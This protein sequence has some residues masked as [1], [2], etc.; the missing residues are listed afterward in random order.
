MSRES[1]RKIAAESQAEVDLIMGQ[2]QLTYSFFREHVRRF[3]LIRFALT[4][5]DCE[6]TDNLDELAS[7]SLSK[8]LKVSKDLV[9]DY[10]AGQ[11]CDGA[12]STSVKRSLLLMRIQEAFSVK[13][14]LQELMGIDT[15]EDVTRAVWLHLQAAAEPSRGRHREQEGGG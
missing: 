6:D 14:S 2:E 4:P 12:T 3:V 1:I 13:L 7:I 9:A 10:E 15:L 5:S 8:A 11:N